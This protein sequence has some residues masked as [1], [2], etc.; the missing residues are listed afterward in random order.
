VHGN[1]DKSSPKSRNSAKDRKVKD[2]PI[3]KEGRESRYCIETFPRLNRGILLNGTKKPRKIEGQGAKLRSKFSRN[4]LGFRIQSLGLGFRVK[5]KVK[6]IGQK[7]K[8]KGL[9]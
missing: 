3:S 6:R 9:D 7:S 4:G 1:C 5:V 8:S 2:L